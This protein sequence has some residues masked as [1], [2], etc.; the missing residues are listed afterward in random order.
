MSR[1]FVTESDREE[2]FV[3]PPLALPPGV[4]NRITPDGA[5]RLRAELAALVAERAV[6]RAGG[7]EAR[8][9]LLVVG[10]RITLIEA[11]IPTWVETPCRPQPAT[12]VFGATVTLSDGDRERSYRIVGIDEAD[13]ARGWI[14]FLAPIAT[15][16]LGAAVG[17]LVRVRTP[18]GDEELEVVGIR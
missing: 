6:L 16:V 18:R 3:P 2:A 11:R 1:A 13:P 15:A 12:V 4:P 8:A 17:D 7:P 5:A 9:R 14:S 10:P